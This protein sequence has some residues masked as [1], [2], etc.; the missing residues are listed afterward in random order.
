MKTLIKNTVLPAMM[1]LASCTPLVEYD[2]DAY[3]SG[4]LASYPSS[5]NFRLSLTDAP[6]DNLKSVFV[7][8]KS[9]ELK[10]ERDG[11]ISTW[12]VAKDL[13]MVDLLTLQNGKLQHLADLNLEKRTALRQ[14]RLVLEDSGHYITYKDGGSCD[15]MMPSSNVDA[16]K[17]DV[18]YIEV[19]DY[20]VYSFVV[21]FDAKKSITITGGGD[22]ILNPYLVVGGFSSIDP[23]DL[24][25]GVVQGSEEDYSALEAE[26]FV[27]EAAPEAGAGAGN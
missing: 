2:F 26:E 21:D 20:S 8:I 7:N 1:L 27:E 11:D 17:L 15:L 18:P 24:D 16:L 5:G 22:C 23:Y 10:F 13:G 12:E 14:V 4:V 9:V 6:N 19:E 25:G 3:Q